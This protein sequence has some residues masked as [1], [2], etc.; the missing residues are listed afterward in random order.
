MSA[1][2]PVTIM[3]AGDMSQATLT[4]HGIYCDQINVFSMVATGTSSGNGTIAFQVSNDNVPVA[5]DADPATN[6]VNWATLP[7][8]VTLSAA[9]SIA[10]SLSLQGYLWCRCLYTKTSGTGALDIR[11][12]GKQA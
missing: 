11:F 8:P 7:N 3:S 12:C 5:N 9:S 2:A 10:N 6:V 1:F 4:S